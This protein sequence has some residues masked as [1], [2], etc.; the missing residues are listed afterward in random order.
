MQVK[1]EGKSPLIR[2]GHRWEDNITMD[3]KEIRLGG[4]GLD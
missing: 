4:E 2:H 1:P 3:F